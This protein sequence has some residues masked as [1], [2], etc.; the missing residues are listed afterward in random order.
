MKLVHWPLMGGMLQLV[1]RGGTGRGHSPPRPLLAH[2]STASVPITVLLPNNT[3][4]FR[5]ELHAFMLAMRLIRKRKEKNLIIFS[6]SMSSLQALN[7]F[8]LELDL[9]Q[10]ILKD[11]SHL[12]VIGKTVMLC[13]ISSH[14]NIPGNEKADCAAKSALSVPNVRFPAYDLAPR[15]LKFCLK[16]WQDIW[17]AC[18]G[19]KLYG[20]Y[21][22]VDKVVHSCT[23][24]KYRVIKPTIDGYQYKSSLSR[25]DAVLINRLRIGHTRL[26][27]YCQGMINQYVLLVSPRSLLSTFSLYVLIC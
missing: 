3:S 2:P 5:V 9:I 4:I 20:I 12:T 11:Y 17:D 23:A 25:R 1:Q 21:P 7:G 27:H 14:V 18:Q 8:K 10:K 26:T 24:N 19:N 6:D 15:V 16:E 22:N 13:W